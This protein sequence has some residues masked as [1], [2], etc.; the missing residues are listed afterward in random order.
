MLLDPIRKV[1]VGG[2]LGYGAG[3]THQAAGALSQSGRVQL[4]GVYYEGELGRILIELGVIGALLFLAL[5]VWLAW[6]GWQ[7][8]RRAQ[9][10]WTTC[11]SVFSF[12]KLFLNLGVGMVVFNHISSALYWICA[13]SAVWVW[14]RQEV[15]EQLR[16]T[17]VEA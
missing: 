1:S 15:R 8:L 6:I 17:G 12:S 16:K 7:A 11:L 14:S 5:K 2:F 4:D 13:G 10:A 3:S 9:G